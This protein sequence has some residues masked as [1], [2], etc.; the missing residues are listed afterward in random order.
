M[1]LILSLPDGTKELQPIMFKN[2]LW[3]GAL[4]P[5]STTLYPSAAAAPTAG[6]YVAGY[7]VYNSAPV[8]G[9]NEGWICVVGGT[10]GTWKQFGVIEV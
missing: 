6:T 10:P 7:Q 9:G 8:A 2:I 5:G 3:Y 1:G 4:Q